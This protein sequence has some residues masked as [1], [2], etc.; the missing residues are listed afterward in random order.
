MSHLSKSETLKHCLFTYAHISLNLPWCSVRRTSQS[1][2]ALPL[3]TR[4]QTSAGVF[5]SNGT[6]LKMPAGTPRGG[7]PRAS[8]AGHV[9]QLLGCI[10]FVFAYSLS[11][12]LSLSLSRKHLC[13]EKWLDRS[14]ERKRKVNIRTKSKKKKKKRVGIVLFHCGTLYKQMSGKGNCCPLLLD[15]LTERLLWSDRYRGGTQMKLKE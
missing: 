12:S 1:I 15:R 4:S 8:T 11:L 3:K 9:K 6:T 2:P 13:H 14:D 5:Q 7:V 10:P